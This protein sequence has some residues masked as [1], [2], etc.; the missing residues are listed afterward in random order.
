MPGAEQVPVEGAGEEPSRR[1]S[2]PPRARPRTPAPSRTSSTP[3]RGPGHRRRSRPSR[4]PPSPRRRRRGCAP[5]RGRRARVGGRAGAPP[6]ARGAPR[7]RC[8]AAPA[9]AAAR[10]PPSGRGS[11]APRRTRPRRPARPRRPPRSG[12]TACRARRKSPTARP[13]AADVPGQ[14]SPTMRACRT[15]SGSSDTIRGTGTGK[16]QLR[17]EPRHQGH[18]TAHLR[19]DLGAPRRPVDPP[20][21]DQP[22]PGV[23]AVVEVVGSATTGHP[24]PAGPAATTDLPP[25][26]GRYGLPCG[27]R[28]GDLRLGRHAHPL[29]RRGLPCRVGGA[30]RG[31]DDDRARRGRRA[32]RAARGRPAV[33]GAAPA[34][35]SRARRWP[36]SS[37]RPGSTTT[38]PC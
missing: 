18:L 23:P 11:P 19:L 29:A 32:G 35:T 25:R 5:G 17:R 3:G 15:I 6:S 1:G 30:G 14:T 10:R 31:G 27:P 2:T 33:S 4:S 16:R 7:P 37:T 26:D 12:S 22:G 34:T 24:T 21:V 28:R 8:A 36:T 13:C 20:A 9:A 38:R